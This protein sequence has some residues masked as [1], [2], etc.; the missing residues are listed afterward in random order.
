VSGVDPRTVRQRCEP[1]GAR[2]RAAR[3]ADDDPH[4]PAQRPRA[5]QPLRCASVVPRQRACRP[6]R[7]AQPPSRR[8]ARGDDRPHRQRRDERAH[9]RDEREDRLQAVRPPASGS[10][11]PLPTHGELDVRAEAGGSHDA[12]GVPARR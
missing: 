1:G 2:R 9:A 8:G 10:G 4:R 3:R 12:E 7:V 5:E 6:P 11:P